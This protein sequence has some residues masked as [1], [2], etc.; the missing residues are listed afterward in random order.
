MNNWKIEFKWGIIYTLMSLL[1]M[2]GEKL[3]G[4]HD[5]Y[6]H[7]HPIYTNLILIPAIVLFVLAFR[8][9]KK[10]LGVDY[11]FN[12]AFQSGIRMTLIIAALAP[13]ATVIST[14][15]ISPDYFQNAIAYAAEQD[16]MTAEQASEYFSLS[17]YS[18]QSL[19]GAATLG[20]FLSAIIGFF[21]R[22]KPS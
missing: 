6:I 17:N 14:Q 16:F 8:E 3:T 21:T 12:K 7:L 10:S 22:V 9:K 18:V 11:T 5:Q 2:V 15:L 4:L 13:V 19:I 20:I 1:W